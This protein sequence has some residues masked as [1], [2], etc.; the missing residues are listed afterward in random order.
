MATIGIIFSD[1]QVRAALAGWTTE[2]RVPIVPQ[3]RPVGIGRWQWGW[4]YGA[5]KCRAPRSINWCEETL[6]PM[7]AADR[8]PLTE[9][10]EWQPGDWLWVKERW[11]NSGQVDADEPGIVYRATDPEWSYYE[12][13]RWR[14]P[15][16]MPR[17]A[18]RLTLKVKRVRVER[19]SETGLWIW[20][21]V[22][23]FRKMT[24]QKGQT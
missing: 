5:S 9:Y 15:S 21:W 13:W 12:G 18:S 24:K 7:H 8:H 16:Q 14:S 23:D 17:W 4:K 22:I 10:A 11:A 2:H 3:P 19:R 1:V 6:Y 20:E